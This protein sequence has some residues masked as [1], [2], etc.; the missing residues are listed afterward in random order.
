MLKLTPHP[1][2]KDTQTLDANTI[3]LVSPT[4]EVTVIPVDETSFPT[5]KPETITPAQSDSTN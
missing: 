5:K 1:L 2:P 4:G 3:C